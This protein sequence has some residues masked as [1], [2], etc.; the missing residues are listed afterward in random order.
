MTAGNKAYLVIR[1]DGNADIGV[2]HLMRCLTIAEQ[3]GGPEHVVF[4]CADERSGALARE[5]GYEVRV[6]GTDYRHM[7]QE[8][9]RL[10][11]LAR[12]LGPGTVILVDSYFVTEEY[13]RTLGTYARVYLLEDVPG[14]IWPVAGVIN[15]NAFADR[16]FYQQIYRR[17][18]LDACLYIGADYI[19]LRS[20]FAGHVCR[21]RQQAE[22]LLVTTGG[23][24]RENIAGK[25]LETIGDGMCRIHVVS[26][27][28][29]PHGAWLDSYAAAHP[30]VTVYRQ[31]TRMAELM[32][33]CDLAVT[34]GGTTVYELCALGVPFVCFSYA[35]NQEALAEYAGAREAGLYAGKYH[36]APAETLENI[37]SMVR[38]AAADSELRQ[39][40]SRRARELVDGRGAGRLA[41]ALL[42]AAGSGTEHT[43]PCR[44]RSAESGRITKSGK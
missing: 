5:K 12:D 27:P 21:V 2:G 11:R 18:G 22:E 10:E 6:L 4:W 28:Y 33:R 20:Q 32:S 8:L 43:R 24:D 15:Y 37:G 38:R 29:N 16:G 13:L 26:G 14:H 42:E 19:P 9:P 31:V 23:G 44:N 39:R 3:A 25:I 40:M 34:A 7:L 1:A 36:Q 17:A 35:E 41:E 30:G